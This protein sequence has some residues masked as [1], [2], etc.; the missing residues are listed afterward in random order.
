[1]LCVFLALTLPFIPLEDVLT[2]GFAAM[3][4]GIPR[5]DLPGFLNEMKNPSVLPSCELIKI[6]AGM[7]DGSSTQM[8]YVWFNFMMGRNLCVWRRKPN[9]LL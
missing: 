1:M 5:V 3:N 4:L 9:L 7:T 6:F 8:S 2:T